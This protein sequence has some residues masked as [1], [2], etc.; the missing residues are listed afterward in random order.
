MRS[1]VL[2]L[3][4]CL[5]TIL[6]PV[7]CVDSF[8]QTLRGTVDVVVV[9]GTITNLT[10]PQIVRLNRSKA[11]PLTGRFGTLPITKATVEILIDSLQVV[12]L[13]ETDSGRYQAPNGFVGKIGHA[14]QLRFT[15]QDGTRYRSNPEVMA[16]VPSITKVSTKFNPTSLRAQLYD[17]TVNPYRGANDFFLDWQDPVDQHNYYRWNWKLWE[18]QDWCH[19]CV[20]GYYFVNS[21]IDR[22]L[23]EDCYPDDGTNGYF[24]NEYA[25]RTPCWEIIS[26]FDLNLFDDQFNNG[27]LIQKRQVAQIPYYQDS[28][29]LVEI[30]QTSLTQ[31]AY[32]YYKLFQEQ[33]QSNGG[34]ADPPPTALVGNVRNLANNR[35]NVVGYF[36]ASA[37]AS[38][39]Q[40]LDR[41][42]NTGNYP[43]L[44]RGLTGLEPSPEAL[45]TDPN[46]G[47]QKPNVTF[48]PTPTAVCVDSD[49]RTPNKPEGWQN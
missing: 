5:G 35:E 14:Y 16:A 2:I 38:M 49:S 28:G 32:S 37:V 8:D 24:V 12:T 26:S 31:K 23:Y 46:T 9:D 44:F 33:T 29:C 21:P 6:V 41:K 13:H 40:W 45:N 3:L 15:L 1:F 34:L 11:D 47:K 10:E 39:R 25:C 27:G 30:R 20:Q 19:T 22:K 42:Q 4:V 18:K 36:T 17:G 43:G 48:R 7:A